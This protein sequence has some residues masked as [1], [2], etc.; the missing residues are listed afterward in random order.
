MSE[1]NTLLGVAF[2]DTDFLADVTG[3]G[4]AETREILKFNLVSSFS[5]R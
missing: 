1:I 2:G 5:S 4:G 3:D